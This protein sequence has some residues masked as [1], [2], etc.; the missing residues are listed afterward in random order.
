MVRRR[1]DFLAALI[2]M[3]AQICIIVESH[4]HIFLESPFDILSF[5]PGGTYC[6][7]G[8]LQGGHWASVWFFLVF[9]R[10]SC[11]LYPGD[12]SALERVLGKIVGEPLR[13]LGHPTARYALLS[14]CLGTKSENCDF[15]CR[16]KRNPE[17]AGL[18]IPRSVLEPTWAWRATQ[19]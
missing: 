11:S 10:I 7:L 5:D 13:V 3:L 2:P 14:G 1:S 9:F 8:R 15:R 12:P 4:L 6:P 18:P 19:T 16:P 17:F